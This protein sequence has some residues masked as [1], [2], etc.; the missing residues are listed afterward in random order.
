MITPNSILAQ[1]S[2]LGNSSSA[3]NMTFA[4]ATLLFTATLTFHINY[5][6]T[7][8]CVRARAHTLQAH[9]SPVIVSIVERQCGNGNSLP[10][11]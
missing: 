5:T 10:Y 11:S 8:A 9:F 4:N 3:E 1:S 2:V 7:R 6:L